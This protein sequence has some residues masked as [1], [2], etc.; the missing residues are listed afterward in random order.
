MKPRTLVILGIVFVA[1]A[2]LVKFSGHRPAREAPGGLKPGSRLFTIE[3]FN[4]VAGI[5]IADGT[6]TVELAKTG[7]KWSI[8]S[9][10]N[11][12]ANFDRVADELNKYDQLRVGG[13]PRASAKDLK[14]FGLDP[15]AEGEGV[16][17]PAIV[18]LRD[19]DKK[20]LAVLKIGAER[21]RP[22]GGGGG[23]M[24][25]YADSQYVQLGTGPVVLADQNVGRPGNQRKDWI[26]TQLLSINAEQIMEIDIVDK[27][28]KSYGLARNTNMNFVAKQKA[29]K[30]EVK[31][32]GARTVFGAISYLNIS[33][34]AGP[35]GSIA[36]AF[37]GTNS[38]Y[39]AKTKDG[40]VYTLD[41]GAS[42]GQSAR[43]AHL[44]VGFEAPVRPLPHSAGTN[45]PDTNAVAAIA[46]AFESKTATD[47]KTAEEQQAA[48]APW[49]YL[50]DD[51]AASNLTLPREQVIG[52]PPPPTNA[53]AAT[54]QPV[55]A[56]AGTK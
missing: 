45:A 47:K 29:E 54:E 41:L 40:L 19:A 50:I 8:A 38:M 12:P 56:P 52:I 31:D 24:G 30:E 21:T 22:A 35:T 27:D 34:V 23:G 37:A 53:P 39:R 3:D 6:Q 32:E 1:L 7:G 18:T 10:W 42:N 14:D 11:Y 20:E 28:G 9:A 55:A 33:D 44:S 51:S 46:K 16:T 2:A 48:H 13:T 17:R 5:T 15:S 4:K 26:T 49:I 36:S 43:Y 25:G